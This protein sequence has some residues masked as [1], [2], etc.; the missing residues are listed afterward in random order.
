MP[1]SITASNIPIGTTRPLQERPQDIQQDPKFKEIIAQKSADSDKVGTNLAAVK[2]MKNFARDFER[3]II[4]SMWQAAYA[5]AKGTDG[6][7]VDT[8]YGDQYIGQ[9]VNQAYGEEGG[10]LADA[11]YE[12]LILDY[13]QGLVETENNEKRIDKKL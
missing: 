1:A 10:P 3:Y 12:K 2:E 4:S 6:G 9:M 11:M 7:I 5:S 8:I 13:K